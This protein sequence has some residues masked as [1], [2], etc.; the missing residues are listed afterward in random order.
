MV[1]QRILG[2]VLKALYTPKCDAGSPSSADGWHIIP[3]DAWHQ[4]PAVRCALAERVR[5]RSPTVD[6]CLLHLRSCDSSMARP[7][8]PRSGPPDAWPAAS[9]PTLPSLRARP[10]GGRRRAQGTGREARPARLRAHRDRRLAAGKCV[11]AARAL[12]GLRG[13]RGSHGR[14]HPRCHGW[15]FRRDGGSGRITLR[16]HPDADWRKTLPYAVAHEMHHSYWARHHYDPAKPFTLAG[17]L[18]LEGRADYF[19]GT[20]FTHPA[21][22]TAALDAAAYTAAWRAAVEAARLHRLGHASGRDVRLAAAWHPKAW[23]GYSIGYRLVS[24]RMARAPRID[25]K[26]MSAAPAS[27]FIPPLVR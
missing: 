26:A 8:R 11:A 13:P 19:A 5:A 20:L 12:A 9:S 15:D 7:P 21:P 23:A 1:R 27:E 17:Y 16:I 4:E 2:F 3:G 6:R 22:W 24:E 10:A 25:M 18:V 14:L